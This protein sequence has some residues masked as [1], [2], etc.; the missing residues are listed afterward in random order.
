MVL[1]FNCNFL[2]LEPE[3][4]DYRSS[5]VILDVGAGLKF[6]S[7]TLINLLIAARYFEFLTLGKKLEPSNFFLT[8]VSYFGSH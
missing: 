7:C 6:S 3:L 1:F 5:Q 8:N 4:K 2:R